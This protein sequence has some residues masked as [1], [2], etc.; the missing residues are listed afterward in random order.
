MSAAGK[1][2]T[3]GVEV[4]WPRV[5]ERETLMTGGWLFS[6]ASRLRRWRALF[7]ADG[8]ERRCKSCG[9]P[10]TLF[11]NTRKDPACIFFFFFLIFSL[12]LVFFFWH[13]GWK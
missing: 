10:A 7:S 1:L 12:F 8:A 11:G 4:L 13:C 5:R 2:G 3:G 6:Y 9:L